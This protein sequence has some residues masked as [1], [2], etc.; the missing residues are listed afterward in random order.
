[1]VTEAEVDDFS[2]VPLLSCHP[3]DVGNLICSYSVFSKSISCIWKSFV[4]VLLEA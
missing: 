1:M 2:G 3:A 4:H